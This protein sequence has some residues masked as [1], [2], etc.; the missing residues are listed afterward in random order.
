MDKF[1][2]L[3]RKDE[4]KILQQRYMASLV[5]LSK[6]NLLR[7]F[8]IPHSLRL[9]SRSFAVDIP[10]TLKTIPNVLMKGLGGKVKDM[11]TKFNKK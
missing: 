5:E 1:Q 10:F 11:T 4:L 7:E 2:H 3:L 8:N 6:H 9:L